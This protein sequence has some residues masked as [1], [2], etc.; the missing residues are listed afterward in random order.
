MSW[1]DDTNWI[2]QRLKFILLKK[3]LS[4]IFFKIV[5]LIKVPTFLP[6]KNYCNIK[7]NNVMKSMERNLVWG[8]DKY[9]HNLWSVLIKNIMKKI[10]FNQIQKHESNVATLHKSLYIFVMTLVHPL[11]MWRRNLLLKFTISPNTF[12]LFKIINNQK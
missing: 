9:M 11:K 7:W 6:K 8:I 2:S 5:N 12:T 4:I 10:V 1:N 3:S